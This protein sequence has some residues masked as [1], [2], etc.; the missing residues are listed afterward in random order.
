VGGN[1]FK[2]L[3]GD[4]PS[5]G[6]EAKAAASEKKAPAPEPE[7]VKA[8]PAPTPVAAA[9]AIVSAP[10]PAP[11]ETPKAAPIT[12]VDGPRSEKRVRLFSISNIV[13]MQSSHY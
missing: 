7:P 12:T 4:A 6:Q 8:A 2:I 1:L 10:K 3:L 13:N 5:A 9:P 11:K